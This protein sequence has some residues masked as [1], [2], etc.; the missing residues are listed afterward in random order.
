ML[1]HP[2]PPP[3]TLAFQDVHR[4]CQSMQM[5]TMEFSELDWLGGHNHSVQHICDQACNQHTACSA[6]HPLRCPDGV[7]PSPV[8]RGRPPKNRHPMA[9][10]PKQTKH[11][12]HGYS[13]H[14]KQQDQRM[15]DL[16]MPGEGGRGVCCWRG[17]AV[18]KDQCVLLAGACSVKRPQ[19][20][21]AG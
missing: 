10:L 11:T 20:T 1:A 15:E 6:P 2:A 18:S 17:L 14:G 19:R 16:A 5:E 3:D 13:Q 9:A 12:A 7:P 21:I 8:R 4:L